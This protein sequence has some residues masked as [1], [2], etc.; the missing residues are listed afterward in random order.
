MGTGLMPVGT[1]G[2]ADVRLIA[3]DATRSLLC[4]RFSPDERWISFMALD[5]KQ[6]DVS[7]I[8]V[9]PAAGGPWI[10]ITDGK[11]QDRRQASLVA[12]RQRH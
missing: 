10:Q 3:S 12:G 1:H 2:V 9:M 6:R 4:Q 5:Y 7:T 8:Y 11:K